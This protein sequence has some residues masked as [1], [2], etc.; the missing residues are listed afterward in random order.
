M[1]M[2]HELPAGRPR[3]PGIITEEEPHVDYDLGPLKTGKEAEVFIVERVSNDDPDRS[4][5]LAHKRYRPRK[6]TTKGELAALGFQK[7]NMF[8]ND[9]QYRDGRK[10]QK[11]RDQRAVERS[12]AYGKSLVN[13]RWPTHEIDVIRKLWVA[14]ADVPYPVAFMDDGMLMEYVG[15]ADQAA[16]RLAQARLSKPQVAEAW[17]QM[18]ENLRTFMEVG[19]VHAD[20]ST[21]NLL[22]WEDRLWF[23]DFPQAVDMAENPHALDFLHRD[24]ENVCGWF[25]RH[26]VD[27]D[28]EA[29]FAT[30]VGY[31]YPT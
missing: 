28:V 24:I 14:G 25:G 15:D 9:V 16:P 12:T 7:G 30:L 31:A 1:L 26:G 21:Y 3:P 18:L 29:V 5:L 8:M 4:C 27:C 19:I 10:F 6:V 2:E 11:S 23:I 17:T 20:L 22:W 13:E